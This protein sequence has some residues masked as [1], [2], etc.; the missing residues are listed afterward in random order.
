MSSRVGETKSP[1]PHPID[2]VEA[3]SPVGAREVVAVAAATAFCKTQVAT[4]IKD[5]PKLPSLSLM[6]HKSNP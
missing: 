2:F 6:K 4:T 5:K 3:E 1:I